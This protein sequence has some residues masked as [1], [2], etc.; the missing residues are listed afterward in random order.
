MAKPESN[1][2]SCD[3]L[4]ASSMSDIDVVDICFVELEGVE[5]LAGL[6]ATNSNLHPDFVG[7]CDDHA[8]PSKS[9]RQHSSESRTTPQSNN[10]AWPI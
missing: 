5:R 1:L 2:E 9:T 8:I 3:S 4:M 10:K 7:R 6:S